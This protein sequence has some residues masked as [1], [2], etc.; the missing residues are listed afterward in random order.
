[1]NSV[2]RLTDRLDITIADFHGRKATKQQE[3][4]A[5][6]L[7]SLVNRLGGLALPRNSVARLTD[8][9]DITIADY[10]GRKA[11]K[12]QELSAKFLFSLSIY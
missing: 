9:L 11:T 12:Q 4:S 5:K 2:A 3:L 8:R 6:F 1:M 7:F 10:R